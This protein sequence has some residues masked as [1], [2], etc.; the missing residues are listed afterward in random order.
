MPR[1]IPCPSPES[2]PAGFPESLL[3]FVNRAGHSH[4]DPQF[5]IVRR[6]DYAYYTIHCIC[7]GYGFFRIAGQD[8]LL[9][10]GDI[11]LIAPGQSHAYHSIDG[12]PLELLWAELHGGMCRE[13]F[14]VLTARH[15]YIFSD[16]DNRRVFQLMETLVSDFPS[17]CPPSGGNRYGISAQVYAI[18]MELLHLA[19]TKPTGAVPKLTEALAY[20]QAHFTEPVSI[21]RLADRLHISS[22][23]LIRLFQQHLGVTPLKYLH[24]KRMEYACLLL[25][26]TAMTVEQISDA[27]GM[28][29]A[30]SFC[31]LFKKICA[32][33]PSEYRAKN[34]PLANPL[35]GGTE[36]ADGTPAATTAP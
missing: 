27:V 16:T 14:S 1:S 4:C 8:H 34:R 15:G 20:M 32:L 24:M 9:T 26:S 33:T 7:N 6:K 31:R 25:R 11:F 28:Y 3:F 2:Q 36:K 12:Q 35:K 10:K 19:E 21:G 18:L 5:S 17:C 30:A 22:A 23:G 13:L 29:D